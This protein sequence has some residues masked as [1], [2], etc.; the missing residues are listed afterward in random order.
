VSIV[1]KSFSMVTFKFT[2]S[3]LNYCKQI[4][5]NSQMIGS[6][7]QAFSDLCDLVTMAAGLKPTYFGASIS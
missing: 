1:P 5:G 6:F 2:K 7:T 3:S 4:K